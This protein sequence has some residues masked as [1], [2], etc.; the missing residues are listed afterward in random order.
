MTTAATATA[1]ATTSI[2]LKCH[3]Q[4]KAKQEPTT[5]INNMDGVVLTYADGLEW[6]FN[7]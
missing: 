5:L 3:E 7:F 1:I 2:A 4:R 6:N